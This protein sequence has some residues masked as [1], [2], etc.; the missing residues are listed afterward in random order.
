[1]LE[2]TIL[3]LR[4]YVAGHLQLVFL[5]WQLVGGL[6]KYVA[7]QCWLRS[8]LILRVKHSQAL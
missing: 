3:N 4:N 1:M 8:C 2:E 7:M 5:A 6:R